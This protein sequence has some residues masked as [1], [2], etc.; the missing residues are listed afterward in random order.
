MESF[1]C[2]LCNRPMEERTDKFGPYLSCVDFPKCRGKR[3]KPTGKLCP[4][5]DTGMVWATGKYGLFEGCPNWRNHASKVT[6]PEELKTPREELA[7]PTQRAEVDRLL[8]LKQ[9]TYLDLRIT[10]PSSLTAAHAAELLRDL[11]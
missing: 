1:S 10:N 3:K 4:V 8:R 9:F 5:C 11:G 2:Q 7:S 6:V